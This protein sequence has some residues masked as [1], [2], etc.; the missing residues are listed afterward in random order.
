ME[1]K[2]TNLLTSNQVKV[3]GV[4][5]VAGV[6]NNLDR[7]SEKVFST[8]CPSIMPSWLTRSG[9]GCSCLKISSPWMSARY[10]VSCGTAIPRI[11]CWPSRAPTARFPTRSSRICP[12]VWPRASGTIWRS[13]PRPPARCGG[14]PAAH[15]GDHPGSGGEKRADYPQGRKGR[16]YCLIYSNAFCSPTPPTLCF[17]TWRSL[18][19]RRRRIPR[20]SKRESRRNQLQRQRKRTPPARSTLHRFRRRRSWRMPGGRR[21][22]TWSGGRWRRS[23]RPSSAPAGPV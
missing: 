22:T 18:W 21:R 5:Y 11:W 15:R 14:G 9:S 2:F 20:A 10:S 17:R 19:R 8:I 1:K 4:D 23:R 13:P 6:M 7:T 3:G 12:P 16:Y